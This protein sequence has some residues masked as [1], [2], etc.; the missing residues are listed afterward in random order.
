MRKKKYSLSRVYL[1]FMMLLVSGCDILDWDKITNSG[2]GS[3]S[4][5]TSKSSS[6]S[7]PSH[8][9]AT[10]NLLE[11]TLFTG[12]QLDTAA[13]TSLEDYCKAG[14]TQLIIA[15]MD[16]IPSQMNRAGFSGPEN[17]LYYVLASTYAGM[18]WSPEDATSQVL[19]DKRD[20]INAWW[21]R[22]IQAVVSLMLK[23]PQTTAIVIKNDGTDRLGSR[24]GNETY[25]NMGAVISRVQMGSTIP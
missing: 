9:Q 6:P 25:K 14:P 8:G 19:S 5:S 18:N 10:V 24:L 17:Q 12:Q 7:T 20:Q 13:W 11:R 23:A 4:T 3:T 21:S 22:Y 16:L 2:S 1:S 15:D